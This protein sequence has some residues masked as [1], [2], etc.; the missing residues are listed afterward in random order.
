[1]NTIKK[2]LLINALLICI[3]FSDA[4]AAYNLPYIG[5]TIEYTARHEDTFVHLARDYNL[6]FTEM[7]AA[8]PYVD[9]WLPGEKTTLILPTRH[10]LPNAPREG[11]VIN[12]ADMRL[13]AYINGDNEPYSTPI[14]VGREGLNTP[15]GTTTVVRKKDGPTWRPTA[16]MISEKPEL[17]P[18]YP[19]GPDNP[20]GTH[21]IYLGW[22]TY[23]LHGTNRPFGIGRR[24]SS[25][26]IRLYP[27]AIKEVFKRIPVGTK[28]TVVNQPV[29]MAWIGD[30]LFIEAHPTLE[31]SVAMEEMGEVPEEKLTNDEMNQLIK[32]AGN[33]QDRLRWPAIRTALKERSGYP[34]SIA[35]KP[36]VEVNDSGKIEEHTNATKL[37]TQKAQELY[38]GYDEKSDVW[39]EN[40]K[41]PAKQIVVEETVKITSQKAIKVEAN[42]SLNT[43]HVDEKNVTTIA[44]NSDHNQDDANS[45]SL[46]Q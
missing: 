6:G 35:R 1:M 14:G 37:T 45:Y 24:V 7:R 4:K 29:K 43:L 19:P 33:H 20:M 32:I 25:G 17:K 9:P 27:E 8:N 36:S 21:A 31:Q 30:E 41:T 18:A 22:P 11:I 26:C 38:A 10:I 13:Y 39:R 5:E 2:F 15:I 12:V 44:E 42:K 3:P 34:V 28:V 40:E 23:A 46:N 16:R